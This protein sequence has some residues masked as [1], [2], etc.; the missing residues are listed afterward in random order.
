MIGAREPDFEKTKEIIR[1]VIDNGQLSPDEIVNILKN[2]VTK[3]YAR[4]VRSI[5]KQVLNVL[6]DG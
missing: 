6:R 4:T 2:R 5:T 3:G 1:V